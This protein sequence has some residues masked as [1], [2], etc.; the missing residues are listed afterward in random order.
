M[1]KRTEPKLG[2]LELQILNILWKRGPCSVRDVV[3]ALPAEHKQLY[4]SVLTMMRIM[5]EK[6]YLDRREKGR[7]H[8]YSACLKEKN[9]KDGLLRNLINSAFRGS[10]ESLLVHLLS[11][12]KISRKELARIQQLIEKEEKK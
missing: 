11:E 8:I 2:D 4:T 7:A 10:Y 3:E 1:R 9:V 12:K 6:G 5:H